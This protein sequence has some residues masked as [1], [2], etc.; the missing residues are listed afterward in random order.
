MCS[1]LVGNVAIRIE[2]MDCQNPRGW[3]EGIEGEKQG[4]EE[5][6]K[7]HRPNE[8]EN[9]TTNKTSSKWAK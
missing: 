9:F 1:Y 8:V 5:E 7:S 4:K 6:K 2:E 3:R